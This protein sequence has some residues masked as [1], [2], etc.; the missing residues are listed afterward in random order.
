[1]FSILSFL[2]LTENFYASAAPLGAMQPEQGFMRESMQPLHSMEQ[3]PLE[4][5]CGVFMK[6]KLNNEI[7]KLQNEK[8]KRKKLEEKVKDMKKRK[9]RDLEDCAS[10]YLTQKGQLPQPNVFQ[11]P[12]NQPQIQTQLQPDFVQPSFN[13]NLFQSQLGIGQPP[14]SQPSMQI[15]SQGNQ[16]T[17]GEGLKKE[18]KKILKENTKKE[19]KEERCSNESGRKEQKLAKKLEKRLK[20]QKKEFK[21]KLH[22]LKKHPQLFQP[23][24]GINIQE[25]E[26]CENLSK[27]IRKINSQLSKIRHNKKDRPYL[28]E[29]TDFGGL[30]RFIRKKGS[31]YSDE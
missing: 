11:P 2:F 29:N 30:N 19:C 28:L 9:K 21:K 18:I 6:E 24:A 23:S 20:R 13:Q 7:M 25:G 31:K 15:P 5:N 22:R 12:L 27:Y 17:G 1:M 4:E 8:K 3:M 26:C 10:P 14:L 16:F